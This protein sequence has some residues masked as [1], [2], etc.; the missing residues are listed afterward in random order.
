MSVVGPPATGASTIWFSAVSYAT[1]EALTNCGASAPASS[2]HTFFALAGSWMSRTTMV[3]SPTTVPMTRLS[4]S[5]EHTSELQSPC[6]LVCRLLLEKT[7]H[8]S[9]GDDARS[10]APDSAARPLPDPAPAR[11][12]RHHGPGHAPGPLA[13]DPRIRT[14]P[15]RRATHPL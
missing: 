15:R 9:H 12:L 4:R 1:V 6:N 10:T 2:V 11:P 7:I 14:R 13:N 8:A 3:G 5:E